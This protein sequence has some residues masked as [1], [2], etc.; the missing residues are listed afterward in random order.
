MS[1]RAGV[2]PG[3]QGATKVRE[4]LVAGA[5]T[6]R[7]LRRP[8]R[9]PLDDLEGWAGYM[10]IASD[11]G[12]LAGMFRDRWDT[13]QSKTGAGGHAR[14]SAAGLRA[15]HHDLRRSKA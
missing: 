4:V 14:R 8:R 3:A 1:V 13:I 15:H 5:T 10:N 2:E 9:H 6:L 11:V 12:V 7:A